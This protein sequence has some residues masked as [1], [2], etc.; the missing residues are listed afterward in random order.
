MLKRGVERESCDFCF[1]RKIKCDR[2]ARLSSCSQCDLRQTPCTFE[3][4]DIRIQ[5]RRKNPTEEGTVEVSMSN[6]MSFGQH[7]MPTLISNDDPVSKDSSGMILEDDTL[8]NSSHDYILSRQLILDRSVAVSTQTSMTVVPPSPLRD[9]EFEPSSNDLAFLDSFFLQGSDTAETPTEWDS[10]PNH[11]LQLIDDHEKIPPPAQSPYCSLDVPAEM[12]DTAI[13]AYFNFA[14]LALTFLTREGFMDDYKAHRGSRALVFAVACRGCSFIQMTEKWSLQQLLASRFRQAFLGARS[15]ASSGDTV[16]LDDL[17]A[18]A[19]MVDFGYERGETSPL[20]LQ[21][22]NLLLTHDSLV[23]MTLRYRIETR[24]RTEGGSSSSLSTAIQRQSLL[25][26]YV[27]GWDA[28]HSLDCKMPSRIQDEDVD[29]L[30]T[31]HENEKQSYLA[32]ILDL[33]VI[34]RRM[35]RVLCNPVARRRGAKHQDVENLYEQLEEWRKDA[36]PAVFNIDVSD[37]PSSPERA[38]LGP[39]TEAQR[40]LPIDKAVIKMLEL[41][42]YMQLDACISRYGIEQHG[43]LRGEIVA[44]RVKYETLQA[45]YKIVEVARWIERHA[46]SMTEPTSTTTHAIT[47]LAP[48]VIRNICAGAHNWIYQKAKEVI[49]STELRKINPETLE[50]DDVFEHDSNVEA[51]KERMKSWMGSLTTLRDT[52][53]AATS[54]RDT[55]CLIERLDRQIGSLKA[56][57]SMPNI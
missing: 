49:P 6:E 35:T 3:C 37:I 44:M 54:H 53:A 57:I 15:S 47:D 28:F 11:N 34:A 33:A 23:A 5:R 21:L 43:S 56:L 48:G 1:R 7:T 17:E 13:D 14:T 20:Q 42:C 30:R 29:L 39:R 46:F 31:L 19:L 24:V 40:V 38:S 4:D 32:A 22:E 45:A 18:L 50:S 9:L 12:L 41:N 36:C 16:R 8:V 10:I 2:S 26:W 27:Y 51:S 25:F 55:G 52:A